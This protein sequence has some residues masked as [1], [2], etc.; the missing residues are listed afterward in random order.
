MARLRVEQALLRLG[1]R[2]EGPVDSRPLLSEAAVAIGY[3]YCMPGDDPDRGLP[4]ADEPGRW[5]GEP[6]TRLPHV[7]FTGGY[8]GRSTLDL[9]CDGRHL[10]LAGPEGHRLAR[11]AREVDP[12]GAFLGMAL[13]PRQAGSG[14]ARPT[15]AC[16]IGDH[17]AMLVRPDHVITW[18]TTHAT[19]NTTAAL[20]E[21]TRRALR[22]N[23]V[24]A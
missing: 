5:R 14:T 11:A 10:L 16:G 12:R 2:A 20:S 23:H 13:L 7:F 4:E 21:A 9:V 18:R 22:P 19:P 8:D 15:D 1:D 24:A 3:R 6:G 17:G